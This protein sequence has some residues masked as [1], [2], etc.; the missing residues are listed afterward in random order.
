MR[1]HEGDKT[2]QEETEVMWGRYKP[3]AYVYTHP[4]ASSV[5]LFQWVQNSQ[6]HGACLLGQPPMSGWSQY[7]SSHWPAIAAIVQRATAQL[8]ERSRQDWQ[9][10][11]AGAADFS[12]AAWPVYASGCE[13]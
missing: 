5:S 8:T 1:G 13:L 10:K 3:C 11:G 4:I 7:S 6:P 9:H 2:I 12:T